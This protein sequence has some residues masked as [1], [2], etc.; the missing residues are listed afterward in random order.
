MIYRWFIKL[1]P[2]KSKSRYK[3]TITHKD[4]FVGNPQL[5]YPQVDM[6]TPTATAFSLNT[7][8]GEDKFLKAITTQ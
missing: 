7:D 8:E 4:Q 6:I 1:Y 3:G 5:I 2:G